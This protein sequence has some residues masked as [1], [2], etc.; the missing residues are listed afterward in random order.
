[1][2]GTASTQS[3]DVMLVGHEAVS[4]CASP[5]QV[6]AIT[7]TNRTLQASAAP[8]LIAHSL[9]LSRCKCYTLGNL[10]L[11]ARLVNHTLGSH[12]LDSK[13]N[14]Q[15]Q[16]RE[17]TGVWIQT[18]GSRWERQAVQAHRQ[19]H[20]GQ[21]QLRQL[22]VCN[23]QHQWRGLPDRLCICGL[24]CRRRLRWRWGHWLS[25]QSAAPYS[26]VRLP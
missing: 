22:E 3:V 14:A 16:Q 26:T 20:R 23:R 1:M 18:S 21:L 12:P 8:V 2:V 15:I 13:Q 7:L 9:V 10:P 24:T 4:P 19:L 17:A 25:E 11:V 5:P 6:S